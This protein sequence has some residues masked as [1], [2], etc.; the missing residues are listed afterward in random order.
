MNTSRLRETINQLLQ[1]EASVGFQSI[2]S[3][4][5]DQLSNLVNQPQQA[6]FQ[7]GFSDAL[8]RLKQAS[9]QMRSK[10]EPAQIKRFEEVGAGPFFVE[11]IPEDISR[12]VVA[13]PI[14]PAV[15]QQ[16]VSTLLV[17]RQTFLTTLTELGENLDRIG[18]VASEVTLGE[19][20]VG[21]TIPRSLF[22][23]N[24]DGLIGE[25]REV[26]FILRAF[27]EVSVG[28]A[29]PIIVKQIST[30]DPLF[31]FGLPV[32][33]VVII[34]KAIHWVLD[35]WKKAEDIRKVRA[36]TKKLNMEGGE[37][38]LGMFDD[39]IKKTV[40]A[41]IEA[42]SKELVEAMPKAKEGRAR[43]LETHMS[44][45]LE[46]L[47][48]RIERGMTVEIRFLPPPTTTS[49]TGT[50]EASNATFAELGEISSNLVFPKMADQPVLALPRS[51]TSMEQEGRGDNPAPSSRPR[52][53]SQ[54]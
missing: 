12:L 53:P 5:R 13:N 34:G 49:E 14:S 48:A 41:A 29:E 46:S 8:T 16:A 22:D 45:A 40:D 27:S 50:D 47:F 25:L 19:A 21:F 38:I 11:D 1:A 9:Q 35:T 23:D 15:V 54:S 26:R 4:T 42:K 6:Q 7:V 52:K 30:T 28:S 10:F 37:E 36:E 51:K 44:Y 17:E 20:E 39:T 24:L 31:F 43:E 2:L 3:Q 33:T 18:V 32:A